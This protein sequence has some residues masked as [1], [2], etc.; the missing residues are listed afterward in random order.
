MVAEML[1]TSRFFV[2][3]LYSCYMKFYFWCIFHIYLT[4][5]LNIFYI[6]ISILI[7]FQFAIDF[8]FHVLTL[9]DNVVISIVSTNLLKCKILIIK[10]YL[11]FNDSNFLGYVKTFI[12]RLV[13]PGQQFAFEIRLQHCNK[14]TVSCKH[15]KIGLANLVKQLFWNVRKKSCS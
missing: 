4:C 15:A 2:Y 7:V 12:I 1:E 13:K 10:R 14:D 9:R 6:V 5:L 8:Y 11:Y 3:V